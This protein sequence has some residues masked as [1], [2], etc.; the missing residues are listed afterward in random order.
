MAGWE[1]W[2]AWCS[3]HSGSQAELELKSEMLWG[4]ERPW[5]V[6]WVVELSSTWRVDVPVEVCL[7][8][9]VLKRGRGD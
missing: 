4:C 6:T 1:E 5:P 9:A 2:G 8:H 7:Q 3:R